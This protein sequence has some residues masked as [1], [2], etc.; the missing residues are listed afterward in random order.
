MKVIAINGISLSGKDTFCNRVKDLTDCKEYYTIDKDGP[1]RTV[2]KATVIS[3]ID[4]V[5]YVYKMFFGWDGTKSDIHRRNL[6]ILKRIWIEASNGPHVWTK[7]RI[8]FHVQQGTCKILFIMVREF[9]E[10]QDIV[11][12]GDKYA[13]GGYTLEIVRPGLPIP[14]VEQEFLDSH[15]PNYLYDYSVLNPTTDDPAIPELTGKAKEFISWCA[16]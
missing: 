8:K 10:M 5:K 12:L 6:N 3:T 4:P 16:V 15:P 11:R 7:E 9:E 1:Y 2:S 14:P 13:S